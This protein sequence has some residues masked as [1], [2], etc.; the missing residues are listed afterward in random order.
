[1]DVVAGLGQLAAAF[2]GAAVL[3]W[4][5][6][7]GSRS[8]LQESELSADTTRQRLI[9]DLTARVELLEAENTRLT[10]RVTA[11]ET[12]EN[13]YLKLVHDIAAATRET[14]PRAVPA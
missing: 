12:V 4:L 6:I 2:G 14:V 7:S 10:A 5:F 3:V 11:L 1:M 8:K 9:N 13:L